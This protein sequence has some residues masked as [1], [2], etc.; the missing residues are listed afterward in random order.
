MKDVNYFVFELPKHLN[1]NKDELSSIISI[2]LDTSL[3]VI[4]R[5]VKTD[6]WQVK[7][8][9]NIGNFISWEPLAKEYEYVKG[10]SWPW[11]DCDL[12]VKLD[13]LTT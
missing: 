6:M 2:T 8:Q 9:E 7:S 5:S 3:I 11:F 12:R 4:K 13:F 1:L 10:R